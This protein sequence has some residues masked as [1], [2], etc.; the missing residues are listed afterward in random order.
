M[1][2]AA[3][4]LVLV[5][6]ALAAQGAPADSSGA[7]G[8]DSARAP[9]AI[10][11]ADSVLPLTLAFDVRAVKR[12]RRDEPEWRGAVLTIAGADGAPVELPARVRARGVFRRKL[13]VFPP[14]RLDIVRGKAAGT[15]AAGIGRP[16]LV[17][18]CRG[19]RRFEQYLY[20]EYLIYRSYAVLTPIAFQARLA[21]ITYA[22]SGGATP[23]ARPAILVEDAD[24]MA[25][26]NGLQILE[27]EGARA[28]DLDA[29]QGALFGV[30]Q[31]L[32]GNTDWSIST[33]HNVELA[34]RAGTVFPVPYDFDWSGVINAH[35]ATPNP[36]LRL[37]S[38]T[39]RLY[40]GYCEHNAE[41]PR[42]L[43]L[44]LER[45]EALLALWRE[46]PPG[47]DPARARRAVEYLE[48]FY[49]EIQDPAK[50]FRA[51]EEACRPG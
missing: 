38:V 35:Y 21:R 46:P 19:D 16:K 2:L 18:H 42:V 44:F 30:F 6:P 25:A 51:L 48:E 34:Q 41:L 43:A 23:E 9:A 50:A 7:A 31:Y 45:R 20:E 14:L 36:V 4:A 5:A 28:R 10:Y 39:Q 22:D 29:F 3:L 26:R 12:D 40:R 33:L 17:T 13:C 8:S 1:R 11:A 37:R 47:Y 32:V 24:R 49:R 15:P 27:A